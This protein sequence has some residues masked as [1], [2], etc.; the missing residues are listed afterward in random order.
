[1]VEI[2]E[3]F[4]E[5]AVLICYY[6]YYYYYFNVVVRCVGCVR[7]PGPLQATLRAHTF[8]RQTNTFSKPRGIQQKLSDHTRFWM[9]L[10][11]YLMGLEKT[12]LF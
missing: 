4:G 1:M 12:V 7:A 9:F 3:I 5:K 2:V 6:C 10:C 8:P 11:F